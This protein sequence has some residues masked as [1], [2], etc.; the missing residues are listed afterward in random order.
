MQVGENID[1][2]LTALESLESAI[3]VKLTDPSATPAAPDWSVLTT[4]LPT[5]TLTQTVSKHNDQARRHEELTAERKQSVLRHLI[6]LRSTEF[7]T[8]E[9]EVEDL[10]DTITARKQSAELAERRLDEIR[11]SKFVTK[12]MAD[13]LTRDLA[14]VYGKDHLSVTVTEDGK[15]YSC[16]RGDEPGTDLSEG[17]RTTLSLLYFLRTLEDEQQP[18]SEASQRIAVSDE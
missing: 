15:S 18:G 12:P 1:I 11:K 7:R 13:T 2:R 10:A 6:G 3:D 14:R 16:R 8:L 17:E 9:Q 4:P 5:S